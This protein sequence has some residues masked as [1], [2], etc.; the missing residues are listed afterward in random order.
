MKD[1]IVI[2]GGLAGLSAAWRLKHHD[3]LL[4]ESDDRIGGRVRSERRGNY[5]LNWGG[6]YM[7][8]LV[9]LQMNYLTL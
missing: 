2:G 5:W 7:L 3:I 8:D 6:T 9:Q 4:L 1:V